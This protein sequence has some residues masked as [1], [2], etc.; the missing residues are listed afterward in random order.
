MQ[1]F[2]FDLS[3][4]SRFQ[5]RYADIITI[6]THLKL[7]L[8]DVIHNFKW[9]KI[10]MQTSRSTPLQR[11]NSFV[12]TTNTKEFLQFEIII[13]VQICKYL[14][15]NLTNASNFQPLEVVDRGSETQP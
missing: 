6:F 12:E 3:T 2:V 8:A 13:N 7:C 4:M 14:F 10:I 9:V 15:S 1:T 11:W 5:G